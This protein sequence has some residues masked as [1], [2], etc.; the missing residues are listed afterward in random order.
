MY[1]CS[2]HLYQYV[3]RGPSR[4]PM[5]SRRFGYFHISVRKTMTSGDGNV[6]AKLRREQG[7]KFIVKLPHFFG[8]IGVI[9][10]RF[11]GNLTAA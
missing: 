11:F 7:G 5:T 6:Q 1:T 2:I 4:F 10:G 8:E 3:T 9:F